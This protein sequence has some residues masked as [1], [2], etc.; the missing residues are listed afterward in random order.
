M[1]DLNLP[2]L[3]WSDPVITFN[4][5]ERKAVPVVGLDAPF[6]GNG[7]VGAELMVCPGGE[8]CRCLLRRWDVPHPTSLRC[9]HAVSA[10]EWR[11]PHAGTPP[12]VGCWQAVMMV[13]P[14]KPGGGPDRYH[15]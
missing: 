14:K 15:L 10:T 5:S 8:N 6:N 4:T 1:T 9:H 12:G 13:H 2:M 11:Q 7:L 3:Q